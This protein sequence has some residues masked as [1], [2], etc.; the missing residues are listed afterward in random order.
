M[1]NS[2]QDKVLESLNGGNARAI[3]DDEYVCFFE[4]L[5]AAGTPKTQLA[6]VLPLLCCGKVVKRWRRGDPLRCHFVE[7]ELMEVK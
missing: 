2:R 6:V 5:L 7:F 1:T 3:V 4:C